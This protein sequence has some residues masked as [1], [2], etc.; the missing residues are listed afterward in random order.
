MLLL[1]FPLRFD[2]GTSAEVFF[3]LSLAKIRKK[4][5]RRVVKWRKKF[6]GRGKAA[7]KSHAARGR[8]E[9]L[10]FCQ[11]PSE[12]MTTSPCMDAPWRVR[13]RSE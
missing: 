5:K 11:L 12:E 13:V 6:W 1:L 10:T 9:N 2:K 3:A 7:G 4:V 8:V